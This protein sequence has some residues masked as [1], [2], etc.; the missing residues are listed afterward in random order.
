[1]RLL[2]L[3]AI[4]GAVAL[5]AWLYLGS[6]RPPGLV[7]TAR[8]TV[9]PAVASA[10]RQQLDSVE[11]ALALAKQS[12]KPVPVTLT[13]RQQE[14]TAAAAAY[15]PQTYAALTLSD[16][17]V[18]LGSGQVKL[19]TAASVLA[20]RSTAVVAATPYVA[21]GRPAVRVDQATVG[22]AALPDQVRQGLAS[23]IAG[24]I[25][26]QVPA[27]L[28]VSSIVVGNGVLTIQGVANP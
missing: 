27:N 13:F 5:S 2:R 16:P 3:L 1:M 18:Q 28:V 21:D 17:S 10:V 14:L 12:G 9:P 15:F 19:T 23:D 24:A 25:A 4:L 11:R 7:A 26:A 8:A 22:G 6:Q 20:F